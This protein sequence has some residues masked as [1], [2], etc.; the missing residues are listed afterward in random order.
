MQLSYSCREGGMMSDIRSPKDSISI[1]IISECK[2]R[3]CFGNI[4]LK[5]GHIL[6]FDD[7][8]TINF[9]SKDFIV[10]TVISLKKSYIPDNIKKI[11]SF[12]NLYTLDKDNAF[13]KLLDSILFF[14]F[15]ESH[16]IEDE[17]YKHLESIV[18]ID[19]PIKQKLTKG[20]EI[21]IDIRTRAYNHMDGSIRIDKLAQEYNICEK[22]I[23]NS[24]K[25]L[26][27]FTPKRFLHILKLNLVHK[28]LKESTSDNATVSQIA[29]RWGFMH[30]GRLSKNY[31][32]LFNENPS[33]TLERDYS[34]YDGMTKLCVSR[35]EEII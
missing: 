25:S 30:L 21:A 18:L 7:S 2:D 17:I 35:Q 5:K 28:D 3:A 31:K 29:Y 23:Q 6:F 9:M 24:F 8:D 10:V 4:K 13:S 20:E 19:T 22:T 11:Y 34:R 32:E 15:E 27:G 26:F 14:D 12:L 1:A 33:I 16:S